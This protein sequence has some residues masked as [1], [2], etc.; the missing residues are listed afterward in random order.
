MPPIVN[1]LYQASEQLPGNSSHFT[2][3]LS[4]ANG[5]VFITLREDEGDVLFY[6]LLVTNVTDTVCYIVANDVTSVNV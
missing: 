5:P 6:P 3:P 2:G 1:V 4:R